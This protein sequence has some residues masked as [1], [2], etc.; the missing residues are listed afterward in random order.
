MHASPSTLL[1]GCWCQFKG[2]GKICYWI[3]FLSE[4]V[5]AHIT[6]QVK[7]HLHQLTGY[8]WTCSLLD[9]GDA[10]TER[11]KNTDECVVE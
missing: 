11:K 9:K 6:L 1:D 5:G 3:I 7:G 8:T 4:F 2:Y 10:D